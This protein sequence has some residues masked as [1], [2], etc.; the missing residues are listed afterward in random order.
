[1]NNSDILHRR[2]GHRSPISLNETIAIDDV[3]GIPKIKAD[4]RNICGSCQLGKQVWMPHKV[5]QHMTTTRT[6]KLL[7]IDLMG[8]M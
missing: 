6:L 5:I 2:L 4:P 3:L 8:P 1:M 7:H